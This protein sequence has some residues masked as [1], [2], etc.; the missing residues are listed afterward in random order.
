MKRLVS[1]ASALIEPYLVIVMIY[2]TLSIK[3]GVPNYEDYPIYD[4]AK[5]I[6]SIEHCL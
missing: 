4:M 1:C 6:L 5:T 3:K 2:E